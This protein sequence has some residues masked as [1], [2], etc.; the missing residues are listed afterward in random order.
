MSNKTIGYTTWARF[1]SWLQVLLKTHSCWR[2]LQARS[3]LMYSKFKQLFVY[4]LV[5]GF[6]VLLLRV[7]SPSLQF[8]NCSM[9]YRWRSPSVVSLWAKFRRKEKIK[10]EVWKWTDFR[11]FSIARKEGKN[12]TRFFILLF[13]CVNKNIE[14][15][16]KFCALHMVYSQIW[17]NLPWNDCHFFYIF[18][19][20]MSPTLAKN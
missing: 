19:I 18:L 5:L 10:L 4:S 6:P 20:C 8:A 13:Q 9:L 16:L 3:F 14:G 11:G 17:L 7:F 2:A 1:M 12:T 15:W